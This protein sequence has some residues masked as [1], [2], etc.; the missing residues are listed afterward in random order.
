MPAP[1][2]HPNPKGATHGVTDPVCG[3]SIEPA[4]AAGSATHDGATC[5]FL[6]YF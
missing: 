3:M 2:G 5:L 4:V 6:T 1:T